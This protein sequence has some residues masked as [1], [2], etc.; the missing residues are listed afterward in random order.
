M[1]RRQA[2]VETRQADR[3][4][5]RLAVLCALAMIVGTMLWTCVIA[6]HQHDNR[7]WIPGDVW[8]PIPAAH[9]VANGAYPFLYEPT[10]VFVYLPGLPIAL[11]PIAFIG[12][13]FQMSETSPWLALPHPQLW[14]L[15]GPYG[16]GM[17]VFP[18][19]ALRRL[20][21][22]AHVA[23][24]VLAQVVVTGT[25]LIPASV[26]WGHFEEPLVLACLLLACRLTIADRYLP[27][28]CSLG[29]AVLFKQTALL[30]VPALLFAAPSGP[31]R[32]RCI[33]L[34]LGIPAALTVL[35]F[36]FDWSHAA[37]ALLSAP[38]FPTLGRQALWVVGRRSP[39]VATP[40]RIGAVLAAIAV[41]ARVRQ[42]ADAAT[43]VAASAV[44][45][46]MRIVAE[47]VLYPYFLSVPI[48]LA[49]VT[50]LVARR[51]WLPTAFASAAAML[52]FTVRVPPVIWWT[53]F[54][55]AIGLVASGPMRIL[56]TNQA[57]R[58]DVSVDSGNTIPP[59]M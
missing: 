39:L 11:A 55:S 33:A 9:F 32:R 5:W 4:P 25:A 34:A 22:Q 21:A 1:I 54:L 16:V 50:L 56:L 26:V 20:L 52:V 41:G 43:I 31:V 38:S 47:P 6:A 45:S 14:L 36:A 17:T 15:L 27:A 8:A 12:E 59:P 48:A 10:E 44:S 51:T 57:L 46:F 24:L 35:C 49:L 37:P 29:A 30:A 23:D 19:A 58:P 53:V 28:A 2:L 13:R 40:L 18:L 3:H 42:R 7:W